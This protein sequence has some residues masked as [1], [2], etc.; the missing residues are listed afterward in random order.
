MYPQ[1]SVSEALVNKEADKASSSIRIPLQFVTITKE[2]T[3]LAK[4]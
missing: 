3:V 4:H 1:Q 2:I